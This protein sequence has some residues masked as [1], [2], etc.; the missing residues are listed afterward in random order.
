M[1]VEACILGAGAQLAAAFLVIALAQPSSSAPAVQVHAA[2][3]LVASPDATARVPFLISN[4]GGRPEKVRVTTDCLGGA[5]SPRFVDIELDAHGWAFRCADVSL[6]PKADTADVILSAGTG[7]AAV[8]VVRGIDLTSVPW[9]RRFAPRGPSH[10]EL[11]SPDVDDSGWETIR[12]PCQWSENTDAW[13]RVH[14]V[15]PSVWKGK[16]LR[17]VMGAVDD[18]DVTYL[19]GVKIGETAGWDRQRGYEVPQELVRWGAENVL[20][21]MVENPTYGGGLYRA[22]FLLLAGDSDLSQ[23][24]QEARATASRA[25]P[26]RIGRPLPLRPMHVADGVLRY[27]DGSEVALWGVN[28]YPQSWY[29]YQNM[30]RLGVDMRAAI[31]RDVDHLQLMGV[32]VIRIHVFDREISDSEG[33]LVVNEHLDLLDYLVAECSRRGIYMFLTPIAWWF[34]PDQRPDA[35]SVLASK[36][37][38]MFAPSA[39]SAAAR[40]LREFLTHVNRYTGR[41][42]KDEPC[43]C[44]LEVQNEPAYLLYG[45]LHGSTYTPQGEPPE[46]L[47]RDRQTFRRLWSEW[48][49]AHGLT[50]D[51]AVFPLFRYELMRRYIREMVTA[52]RSTGAHQPIAV[53]YFGVNGDDLVQ[54]I[55]DS[56]CEAVTVSAYPGGWER[57]NDGVNL[58]AQTAPPVVSPLLAGKAR[59]A[60]EFD[61]PA[62]NTSCYLYPAIAVGFR[63]A[64]VQVACQFQYDSVETAKWNTDWNAHWLNW[65]YT[66]HKAV[67]FMAAGEAFRHLPRG[68]RWAPQGGEL[69]APGL[70][71][72]FSKNLS[73]WASDDVVVHSRPFS[74]EAG[75]RTP[76][77]PRR[78]VGVGSSPYV[79]YGGTGVYELVRVSPTEMRLR[80]N[81]DARLV[82]NSLNGGWDSPVCELEEHGHWFKLK[83]AG[84][85][86][87]RCYRMNT[88]KP[89]VVPAVD[90]G[91]VLRPG[92]YRISRGG[93]SAG[94]GRTRRPAR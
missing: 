61:A 15:V 18:N 25:K 93:A 86:G 21:V 55:A 66:P 8:R 90:G 47:E 64:E 28:Y 23:P 62:T 50:D 82:G 74:T 68:V 45:D 19:N 84:W 34:S 91:W 27:A 3:P 33:R 78:I 30:K 58:L 6:D 5:V 46:V 41:E 65:L 29:Q 22:P 67:S 12:P 4:S 24:P 53:S 32:D 87:A 35:F 71:A 85:E 26:G 83:I 75:I 40:Y 36:P 43:L 1:T 73:L 9:K 72:S 14:F 60:Y 49:D 92:S 51:S 88:G 69:R 7:R 52:I 48:L 57:V 54:A 2:S 10:G 80:V 79:E 37:G 77:S 59:L 76:P 81:P 11:A 56:E 17:L 39:K 44:L 38:M 63:S 20:T 16:R 13:C 31:R 70:V 94:V 42:Y 89:E